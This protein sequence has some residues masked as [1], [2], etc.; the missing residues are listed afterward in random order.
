MTNRIVLLSLGGSVGKTLLTTQLLHS[1]MPNAKILCVDGVSQ[2]ARDFGIR[3]CQLHAGDEFNK[4]YRA[5]MSSNEDVI[6][7][8]GGSKEA[9]EYI[10]G[11]MAI[12]GAD[13]VTKFIIPS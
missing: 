2:T 13:E 3:N 6:V 10:G 5:L 12:D 11:M 8:V 1:H 4:T 9:K 7:D